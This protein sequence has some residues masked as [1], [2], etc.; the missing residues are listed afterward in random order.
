MMNGRRL[1][2]ASAGQLGR[3]NVGKVQHAL[4]DLVSIPENAF[5]WNLDAAQLRDMKKKKKHEHVRLYL[6]ETG[7]G[8]QKQAL[9]IQKTKN[10]PTQVY[11]KL[12]FRRI[13]GTLTTY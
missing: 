3:M 11:C 13:Y 9:A 7:S 4:L 2:A 1:V 6:G 10:Y 5:N 8:L 12:R